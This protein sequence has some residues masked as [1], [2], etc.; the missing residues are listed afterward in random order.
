MG[1][2]MTDTVKITRKL[3]I[4]LAWLWENNSAR[5]KVEP[6][7]FPIITARSMN[8]AQGYF[9]STVSLHDSMNSNEDYSRARWAKNR[10][11]TM[12]SAWYAET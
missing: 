5:P 11:V 6:N 2:E 9:H 3:F 10:L 8:N 1:N 7:Y 4:D 12:H